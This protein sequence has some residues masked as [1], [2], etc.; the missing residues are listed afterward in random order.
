MKLNS[1]SKNTQVSPSTIH[2]VK[3]SALCKNKE[4][5]YSSKKHQ[6]PE[7]ITEKEYEEALIKIEN[8]DT[9][10]FQMNQSEKNIYYRN[11]KI[12]KKY[13]CLEK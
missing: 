11:L 2:S 3:N 4:L 9:I 5:F 12:I 7:V 10:Y 8:M 1:A 6:Q 13:L